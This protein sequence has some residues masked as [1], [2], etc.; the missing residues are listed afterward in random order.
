MRYIQ[1]RN[2][3]FE[4]VRAIIDERDGECL[5]T[6]FL[7]STQKISIAC[8]KCGYKWDISPYKILEGDWCSKCAVEAR[9]HT[10]R[11]ETFIKV[12]EYALDNNGVCLSK[13]YDYRNQKLRF[14]CNN[15]GHE[16]EV[17]PT[18]MLNGGTWCRRCSQK[19]REL[20]PAKTNPAEI[21]N[22]R[23]AELFDRVRR[24]A[25]DREG[26][27]LSK[28]LS[29]GQTTLKFRCNANH[30]W[31]TRPYTILAGHW[32]K[33][34]GTVKK[35]INK[36]NQMF[37]RAKNAALLKGGECLSESYDYSGQKLRFR[38]K[39]GNEWETRPVDVV[40][41]KGTWCPLC[42]DT[43]PKSMSIKDRHDRAT[44][45]SRKNTLERMYLI[46]KERGGECISTEYL[47][48]QKKLK[49]SCSCGNIWDVNPAKITGGQW[50]RECSNG[51]SRG[52]KMSRLI[53]EA[54]FEKPFPSKRPNWL[55]GSK[56]SLLELDCYNEEIGLA[57]EYQGHQHYGHQSRF[58]KI[59]SFET[60]AQR[61]EEKRLLVANSK[62]EIK[63]IEIP[64]F[65]D[66]ISI[67]GA[68]KHIKS[69]LLHND[70]K[71]DDNKKISIDVAALYSS[72]LKDR[73]VEVIARQGG[74]L[75]SQG[76]IG[77][78]IK[79]E[80]ECKN[81]H[82]WDVTPSKLLNGRWCNKCRRKQQSRNMLLTIDAFQAKATERGG[83]FRSI[84]NKGIGVPHEWECHKHG[85]FW[86]KPRDVLYGR[87]G[88]T[89]C[90][91]CGIEK[92]KMTKMDKT[93]ANIKA[94]AIERG[95]VCLS[96]SYSISG[97]KLDFR[98]ICGNEWPANP[99]VMLRQKLWCPLCGSKRSGFAAKKYIQNSR[100]DVE[101]KL[102]YLLF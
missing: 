50:C 2:E 38:C 78:T 102:Q 52:E 31:E 15:C 60:Q 97:Q 82:V 58:H 89:W 72:D 41:A 28:E 5:S 17:A 33:E 25:M 96:E 85:I 90:P 67:D 59:K 35:N 7:S 27:C 43:S 55:R 68:I 81:G 65:K 77:S 29:P 73:V 14:R 37:E 83:D 24:T 49:F 62:I 88:G 6:E 8:N 100:T 70:V 75:L 39:C 94:Y 30:T 22:A 99:S 34:C 26:E 64:Y 19:K 12:T 46:A 16:W 86:A 44:A 47:P 42:V 3:T 56:G 92:S 74:R 18:T 13:N 4:K 10:M 69:I 54:I 40:K 51:H 21:A 32:C 61:D 1:R 45:S 66:N 36:L 76:V 95:G 98:C 101:Q 53:L 63:L 9:A 80:V 48:G 11:E 23:R 71:F 87:E 57:F 84:E 93:F 91:T 79:V 20:L